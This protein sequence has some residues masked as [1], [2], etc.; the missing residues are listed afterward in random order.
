MK[1]SS[2]YTDYLNVIK[3]FEELHELKILY[4]FQEIKII[5]EHPIT[6]KTRENFGF[7]W[8]DNILYLEQ[9]Y[10]DYFTLSTDFIAMLSCISPKFRKNRN[11]C[12]L[13]SSIS[14]SHLS[15]T[16][17]PLIK[18]LFLENCNILLNILTSKI[19][20]A[21]G[22]EDFLR[23]IP[24]KKFI[25]E[26]VPYISDSLPPETFLIALVLSLLPFYHQNFQISFLKE[27]IVKLEDTSV[28]IIDSQ[29]YLKKI[30][31][32]KNFSSVLDLSINYSKIGLKIYYCRVI[33][34]PIQNIERFIINFLSPISFVSRIFHSDKFIF[35]YMIF[36][37]N[38]K[39]N[40]EKYFMEFKK[41]QIIRSFYFE[42]RENFLYS[43]KFD[44]KLHGTKSFLST[45]P[46][47]AKSF[48]SRF[49][50]RK[51]NKSKK[52]II[53]KSINEDSQTNKSE[54][55][56]LIDLWI[57]EYSARIFRYTDNRKLTKNLLNLYSDRIENSKIQ[58]KKINQQQI[59]D[60]L[61]KFFKNSTISI[62]F[63]S[64]LS[65]KLNLYPFSV[66]LW[67]LNSEITYLT[68]YLFFYIK[69]SLENKK[70]LDTILL[71]VDYY[72]VFT[73]SYLR[74]FNS[75]PLESIRNKNFIESSLDYYK[76]FNF[77][78]QQ[79]NLKTYEKNLDK[80]KNKK[81]DMNVFVQ[82][83][84]KFTS[85]FQPILIKFDE[86]KE[87][88]NFLIQL[89]YHNRLLRYG[90]KISKKNRDHLI[91][92]MNYIFTDPHIEEKQ[93][94]QLW[95]K[96]EYGD[97]IDLNDFKKIFPNPV[98]TKILQ[99]KKQIFIIFSQNESDMR[100]WKLIHDP[101][102]SGLFSIGLVNSWY[103]GG[104]DQSYLI[105]QY[106]IPSSLWHDTKSD[107]H[108]LFKKIGEIHKTDVKYWELENVKHFFNPRMIF[109]YDWRYTDY[110]FLD[111][112]KIISEFSFNSVSYDFPL[113]KNSNRKIYPRIF[114]W[115]FWEI[116]HY[117]YTVGLLI[118][119][120]DSNKD[121]N[122]I[123][124]LIMNLA[125][126]TI[127]NLKISSTFESCIFI[128]FQL[129]Q[130]I[131]RCLQKLFSLL[132][133]ESLKFILI[134]LIPLEAEKDSIITKI[135]QKSRNNNNFCL[136]SGDLFQI[137]IFHFHK[138]QKC[139]SP[140]EQLKIYNVLEKLQDENTH[141]INLTGSKWATI[142]RELD[143]LY[144]EERFTE[145]EINKLFLDKKETV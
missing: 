91:S 129:D 93:L 56:S 71:S 120:L 101:L 77:E 86:R 18:E 87:E 81:I 20:F 96:A 11:L 135:M 28:K 59:I 79:W 25:L 57:I 113:E 48:K 3:K 26:F 103:W 5:S 111:F 134:P 22:L 62:N 141:K 33:F 32:Q 6:E 89:K 105:V 73:I 44:Q 65:A 58:K 100:P 39:K 108:R 50:L 128:S 21:G 17:Y 2:I 64:F 84:P 24:F 52:T 92:I 127:Y 98:N 104:F 106:E 31:K 63:L 37:P 80:V 54:M 30:L 131:E 38:A 74:G 72:M 16:N 145:E 118:W 88:R 107:W 61:W 42:T 99:M 14:F 125:G 109:S 82:K 8:Q 1:N 70:S 13:I 15:L 143:E 47:W 78:Q 110:F 126:G 55:L 43:L 29:N 116:I 85:I 133:E 7:S 115:A 12:L 10:R 46:F 66:V 34:N 75:Y 36:P 112:S 23:E 35:F 123:E 144:K 138:R 53:S 114:S 19:Y 139:Y 4:P 102:L 132:H 119:D 95:N 97:K 124:K 68:K 40:I 94:F 49:D 121:K 41:Q 136:K 90:K 67:I 45:F 142:K 117:G 60:S 69:S 140:E 137:P 130:Q 9:S 51:K 76:Y 83:T 27:K 122:R